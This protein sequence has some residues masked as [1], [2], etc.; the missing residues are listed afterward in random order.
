VI[1]GNLMA[2]LTQFGSAAILKQGTKHFGLAASGTAVWKPV[3][4]RILRKVHAV[5]GNWALTRNGLTYTQLLA[6]TEPF[7]L[8][9]T[10]VLCYGNA[11][12]I[13][14][15]NVFIEEGETLTLSNSNSGANRFTIY[16]DYVGSHI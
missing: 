14:G 5:A 12:V 9:S 8:G 16:W 7:E 4:S 11:A 2:D 3:G 10:Q 6:L 13:D 1:E 15:M